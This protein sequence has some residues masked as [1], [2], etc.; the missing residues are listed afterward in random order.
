MTEKIYCKNCGLDFKNMVFVCW[1]NKSEPCVRV[2][3]LEKQKAFIQAKNKLNEL[4]C[5][6]SCV[7]EFYGIKN[8]EIPKVCEKCIYWNTSNDESKTLCELE[9]RTD[10]FESYFYD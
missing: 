5:S 3:K 2:V 4:F 9:K 8:P 6:R 7:Y 10:Y 1:D